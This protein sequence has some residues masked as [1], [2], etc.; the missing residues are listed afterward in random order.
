M[1]VYTNAKVGIAGLLKNPLLSNQQ[2]VFLFAL[3]LSSASIHI[4]ELL[5]QQFPEAFTPSPHS[6]LAGNDR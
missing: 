4:V 3:F 6:H 1:I 2:G 5:P